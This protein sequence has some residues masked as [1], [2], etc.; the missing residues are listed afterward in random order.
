[1]ETELAKWS[2]SSED[3]KVPRESLR[4]RSMN[5]TGEWIGRTGMDYAALS[6]KPRSGN[7]YDVTFA[8]GG[9]LSDW[10]LRRIGKYAHGVL[11]LD[12]P[13]QEYCPITF[14]TLYA[15]RIDGKELLLP[16]GNTT[17][18]MEDVDSDGHAKSNSI[19][20]SFYTYGRAADRRE[21]SWPF[22]NFDEGKK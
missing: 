10:Q 11:T 5:V 7:E 16:A 1:M 17:E 15:I 9:C 13:V 14:N 12:R 2:P 19:G 18:L 20:V 21:A 4:D 6:I 3:M 8:T 22:Q